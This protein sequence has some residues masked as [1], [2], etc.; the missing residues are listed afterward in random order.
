MCLRQKGYFQV[1]AI[2]IDVTLVV[3][4]NF[5]DGTWWCCQFREVIIIYVLI[6]FKIKVLAPE[7]GKFKTLKFI[8]KFRY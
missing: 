6:S 5:L 2:S 1:V 8:A 4:M 7:I 3:A